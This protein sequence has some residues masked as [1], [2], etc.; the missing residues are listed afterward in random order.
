[1]KKPNKIINISKN[2]ISNLLNGKNS[3]EKENSKIHKNKEDKI[4]IEKYEYIFQNNNQNV[5]KNEKYHKYIYKSKIN[6]NKKII[7][8]Y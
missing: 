6:K 5:Q 4:Y 8:K 1:M 3:L 7:N 2:D